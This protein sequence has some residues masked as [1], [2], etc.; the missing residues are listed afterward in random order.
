MKIIIVDDE[1]SALHTFL[2]DV[3]G[4]TDAD[5]K[6]FKDD[7]PEIC[8]YAVKNN[9][10]AAFL[11]INMPKTNGIELAGKLIELQPEIKIVFITGLDVSEKDLREPVSGHTVG[12]LYK[13]YD[14]EAL[15]R[16]L[17]SIERETPKLTA[18]MFGTFDCFI[19]NNLVRFSSKKSK[20]LFALL[21]TYNGKSLSMTD[22]ISQLWPDMETDKSKPLYRDAVW[23]LRKTLKEIN[24]NCVEFE[25]AKLTLNKLNISC[26]Y[27]EYLE[28]GQLPAKP[29]FLKSYNWSQEYFTE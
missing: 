3:I 4:R 20:E 7:A 18:K 21:L 12:F 6:F 22:A 8:D 14:S 26:D 24:F 1:M 10:A 25:R 23:R 2:S 13:P 16:L 17:S 28:T 29:V 15:L 5:Y 9:I 27:W 19:N 11:D